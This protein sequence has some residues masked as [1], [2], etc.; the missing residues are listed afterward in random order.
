MSDKSKK[1]FYW[2]EGVTRDAVVRSLADNNP[3]VFRNQ[4]NR[5]LLIVLV[6]FLI[7]VS[8]VSIFIEHPKVRSYLEI[9][10]LAS[11]LILYFKLRA[12]VR[13]VADAPDELLD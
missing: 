12:S 10:T 11:V 7:I 9:A 1:D 8:A 2:V 4:R 6:S 3:S 13:H 5:K